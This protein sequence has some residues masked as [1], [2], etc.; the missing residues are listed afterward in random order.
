MRFWMIVSFAATV[1][2]IMVLL[3]WIRPAIRV[4]WQNS[5]LVVKISLVALWALGSAVIIIFPHEDLFSGLDTMT[6]G[7]MSRAFMNGR[8]FHE[9]DTVLACVPESL[10]E[11]FL[12]RR[13][14]LGRPTRDRSFRLSG[15]QSVKTQP[16][17][18]P[19]L[20]LAAA[21]G[22][23]VLSEEQFVP[24]MGS[25]WLALVLAAGFYAGGGWG[26][27]VASA[28]LL[29]TAWPAWFLRGFFPEAVG[30][31]LASSV[32]LA[33]ALRPMR[34]WMWVVAGFVLGF[35]ITYHPT[36]V[37][38]SIPI[39]LSLISEDG[40]W[41]NALRMGAGFVLGLGP[42][43]AINK[44]VCQP[45]GIILDWEQICR[46]VAAS[47][48]HRAFAWLLGIL[49]LASMGALS[50]GLSKSIR[51]KTLNV[52]KYISMAIWFLACA[53][54]LSLILCQGL[55]PPDLSHDIRAG[56][57]SVWTG[58]GWI[59][60][61][62][63]VAGALL[64]LFG[65]RPARERIWLVALCWGAL[66]F[67]YLKGH[68]IPVGLWSQRR[69]LPVV[70]MGI[71][72]MTSPLSAAIEGSCRLRFLRISAAVLIIVA[73]LVNWVRWPAAYAVANEAGSAEWTKNIA[74]RI[75]TNRWVIFD[76]YPHSVP[77]ASGLNQKVLGLGERSVDHWPETAEWIAS[78]AQSQEVWVATSWLPCALED[79]VQLRH[80]FSATGCFPSVKSKDFFPAAKKARL[81]QNHF[82]SVSP[83]GETSEPFQDKYMDNSPIGLREPW[84]RP[85]DSGSGKMARWM[86]Q[87][88][89]II[90][91]V[92]A[93]GGRAR[94][95]MECT[96]QEIT[97]DWSSQTVQ[98]QP[99]WGGE[100]ANT[101]VTSGWQTIEVE[102]SPTA[103]D[104]KLKL[105]GIY[106]L[107]V[108]KPYDPS[109]YGLRG[110]P[111]DLGVQVRRITIWVEPAP[112]FVPD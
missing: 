22:H 12:F 4:R 25:L 36:L 77:Y 16:Y 18:M 105:T 11:N 1:V 49:V 17:F 100:P 75:G 107:S 70:L 81:V 89:G 14:P 84:G 23:P 82:L 7:N 110:Y 37:V 68:E 63:L 35:S 79:N 80:V 33:A 64:I 69:F 53:V 65:N 97:P 55:L 31:M 24:L 2:P 15:W 67:I 66:F 57:M 111:P 90:G 99:P 58:I 101:V 44:Y 72:C 112:C 45:Y 28:L 29:G 32:L 87:G 6:Y 41:R 5:G 92:P 62:I 27:M 26:I 91:P 46:I 56:A 93:P 38:L 74:E 96:F 54:P 51:N 106:S 47:P 83:L 60:G 94:F 85:K 30:G 95:R 21:G 108:D 20:P 98:I 8:G 39:A 61:L 103:G 59:Y 34:N 109:Q 19:L 73:G 13:G 104:E 86:R 76:Y 40:H 88:S 3:A 50:A 48:E 43:W 78:L 71:A 102:M 9:D 52:P 10:R 42:F